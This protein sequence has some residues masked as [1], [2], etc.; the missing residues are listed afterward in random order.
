[1]RGSA[2]AE[3]ARHGQ[4]GSNAA[5]W[6][7]P[8][9]RSATTRRDCRGRCDSH[10]GGYEARPRRVSSREATGPPVTAA[11]ADQQPEPRSPGRSLSFAVL[12]PAETGRRNRRPMDAVLAGVA[13]LATGLT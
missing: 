11:E 5:L 6:A 1:M 10:A 13:A 2:R 3:D 4:A 7:P 9:S 12:T 8:I